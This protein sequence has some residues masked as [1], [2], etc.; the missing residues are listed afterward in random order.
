MKEKLEKAK[1]WVEDNIDML[2]ILTMFG[3][4]TT[5][6]LT[7]ERKLAKLSSELSKNK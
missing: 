4:V 5:I 2:R 6:L 1:N 3:A 7:H